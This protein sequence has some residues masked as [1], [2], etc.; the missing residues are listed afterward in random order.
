MGV[1]HE[2]DSVKIVEVNDERVDF[3]TF[4]ILFC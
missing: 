4:D 2:L 1:V 3:V